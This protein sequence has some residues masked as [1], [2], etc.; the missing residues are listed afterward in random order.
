M[1]DL[2]KMLGDVYGNDADESPAEPPARPVPEW[3][4][5]E[6][7]DRAFA[8]W[9]PGPTDDAPAA[10]R[11]LFEQGEGKLADDLAAALSEAVL[12]E[13]VAEPEV[14]VPDLRGA[15]TPLAALVAV[16]EEA[17]A[18][19]APAEPAVE[20]P[21]PTPTMPTPV[22][23]AVAL[24]DLEPETPAEVV[25]AITPTLARSWQ[26]DHDDIIPSG[27]GPGR[28]LPRPNLPRPRLPRRPAKGP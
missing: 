16:A 8:D 12:A 7:L 25:E 5:D 1:P 23:S 20:A 11:K 10:E 6:H 26:R 2:S 18:V 9:T 21:A 22:A 17:A 4:D 27:R 3:S 15:E 28:S 13:H 19:E 14:T 24:G